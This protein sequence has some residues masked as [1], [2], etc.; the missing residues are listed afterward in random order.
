MHQ[1]GWSSHRGS[2]RLVPNDRSLACGNTGE[3]RP[4]LSANFP[5]CSP[6]DCQIAG[7]DSE[8]GKPQKSLLASVQGGTP[9]E[10]L[11]ESRNQVDP[12]W[13]AGGNKSPLAASASPPAP[14]NSPPTSSTLLLTGFPSFLVQMAS[15]V[16]AGRHLAALPEDSKNLRSSTSRPASGRI[17]SRSPMRLLSR[18]GRRAS[19]S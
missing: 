15:S 5:R 6:D 19:Y 9:Q 7:V 11:P 8:M 13:S 1:T 17:G 3:G 2:P 18:I 16:G 12:A 10:L 4:P 14:R